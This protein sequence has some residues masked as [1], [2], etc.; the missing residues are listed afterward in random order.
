MFLT[1]LVLGILIGLICIACEYSKR[2]IDTGNPLVMLEKAA[3]A[4]R[5][6][7]FVG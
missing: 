6:R 4:S 1:A 2:D 7:G 5:S 3:H